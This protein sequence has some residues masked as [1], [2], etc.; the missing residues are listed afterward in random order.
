M[1]NSG[2]LYFDQNFPGSWPLQ[3]DFDDLEGFTC[4]KRYSGASFHDVVLL[5]LGWFNCMPAPS[6]GSQ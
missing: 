1:A 5:V 4:G 3:V 2:G 6:I